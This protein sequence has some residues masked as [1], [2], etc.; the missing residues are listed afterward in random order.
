MIQVVNRHKYS[1]DGVY[2]GRGSPLGNPYTHYKTPTK[3]QFVVS[4]RREAIE[5]FE[6]WLENQPEDSSARKELNRLT[7][8]Y[9]NAGSLVLI[10]SCAPL[11]C[12]GHV[13]SR[14]IMENVNR[15]KN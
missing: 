5:K 8:L 9:A 7:D 4:S 15:V 12:H 13:I 2:I 14:M 10:C 6:D 11:E 3:A 1:G